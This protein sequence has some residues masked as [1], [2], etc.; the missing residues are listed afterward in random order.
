MRLDY[1]DKI[2]VINLPSRADRRKEIDHQ[3]RR[4]GLS[5][6]DERVVL[7]P[8]VRPNTA[9]SFPSIG[10]HGCFMSHLGVL[11]MAQSHGLN[12]ILILED[13]CD[14]SKHA[15][16]QTPQLVAALQQIDWALFYGGALNT[17]EAQP[18]G[19]DLQ[20]VN[21]SAGLMGSHCI[22]VSERVV[23]QLVAYFEA[24]LKRPAG[25]PEGGPMHVDG[26]YSWFRK[27]HPELISVIADPEWAFQR[28]S[29]TD[30]HEQRWFDRILLLRKIIALLRKIKNI[31]AR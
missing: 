27:E 19:H 28:S 14:F 25:S 29:A 30:V 21:A 26:A 2:F 9:G 22:A 3:L 11:R 4:L 1:F 12:N 6:L 23:P 5:L 31:V 15:K 10:A 7:F 16:K 17:F 24:M 18:L 20:L 13:D 8:A